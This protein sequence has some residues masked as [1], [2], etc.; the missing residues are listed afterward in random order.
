MNPYPYGPTSNQPI[1]QQPPPQTGYY[2]QPAYP[3]PVPA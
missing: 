3:Q 2:P 1:Y